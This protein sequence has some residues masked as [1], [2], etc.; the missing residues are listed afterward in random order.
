MLSRESV[1]LLADPHAAEL[2]VV[3]ALDPAHALADHPLPVGLGSRRADA[4]AAVRRL[5]A[6]TGRAELVK[7]G[8]AVGSQ[9]IDASGQIGLRV[10]CF[11]HPPELGV[12]HDIGAQQMH[13]AAGD[14]ARAVAEDAAVLDR[15]WQRLGVVQLAV[16]EPQAVGVAEAVVDL[17]LH[18]VVV[19]LLRTRVDHIEGRAGDVG[20]RPVEIVLEVVPHHGIDTIAGNRV[21][22]EGIPQER[23]G[24]GR[25]HTSRARVVNELVE[26]GVLEVAGKLL[27]GR[28]EV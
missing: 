23:A 9:R 15:G 10:E 19:T 7:P 26:D 2:D 28:M 8:P 17:D 16:A 12:E 25:V 18:R 5:Q 14:V 24:V 21:L 1:A 11:T 22:R 13:P 20:I 6:D 3:V 27:A 4:R